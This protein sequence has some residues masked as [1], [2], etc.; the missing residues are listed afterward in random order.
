ME[1]KRRTS[2]LLIVL[3]MIMVLACGIFGFIAGE[4]YDLINALWYTFKLF[5]GDAG[6]YSKNLFVNIAKFGAL[7]ISASFVISLVNK[8]S[9]S[10]CDYFTWQKGNSIF[11]YGDNDYSLE[12]IN[13][14][15]NPI[16]NRQTL[17]KASKYVLLSGDEDNMSFYDNNKDFLKDKI[18]YIKNSVFSNTI[19]RDHHF[20]SLEQIASRKYW[21]E[22]SLIDLAFDE[23]GKA[24]EEL[25]I[26]IIGNTQLSEQILFEAIITN[27]FNVEQKVF[28]HMF[29]DWDKFRKSHINSDKLGFIFH[30][31][32]YLDSLSVISSS[33]VVLFFNDD[34]EL[35]T[36][37]QILPQGNIVIFTASTINE[38]LYGDPAYGRNNRISLKVFNYLK[39]I[40]NEEEIISE[41]SLIDA[42]KLN[43]NYYLSVGGDGKSS[44]NDEWAKLS[45]FH[46]L[47][48]LACVDYYNFTVTR[49]LE[50]RTGEKYEKISD[51]EF[52]KHLE[53]LSELEHIRWCNFHYF[54]NW[55]YSPQTD[56][57]AKLHDCLVSYDK[58]SRE[59]QLKDAMQLKEIRKLLSNQII[60]KK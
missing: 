38:E 31:T 22:N 30:D 45:S 4:K 48:N 42:K 6:P 53:H 37:L 54:C 3:S 34:K 23:K 7:I 16:I 27:I 19:V 29:G 56:K 51:A 58:L 46:K 49:L 47:S 40:C 60:R 17:K 2:A 18:V 14:A 35:N 5:L 25:N 44:V 55:I 20:F 57:K 1:K 15:K 28:Y 32:D 11:V 9:E 10:I 41:C 8:L 43:Y 50:K 24:K 39:G 12:F 59:E 36:L 52:E 33:D 21:R 13:N 26:S